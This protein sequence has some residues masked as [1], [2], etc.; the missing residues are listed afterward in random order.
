[1]PVLAPRYQLFKNSSWRRMSSATAALHL[2][3]YLV[4]C[5]VAEPLAPRSACAFWGRDRLFP[6]VSVC[7]KRVGAFP[8]WL[9]EP[10][11]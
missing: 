11:V 2:L 9:Y 1:M 6:T 3:P 5:S 7:E 10:P 4:A 8:L